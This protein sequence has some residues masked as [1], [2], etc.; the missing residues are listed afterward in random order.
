MGINGMC[1]CMCKAKHGTAVWDSHLHARVQHKTKE[2]RTGQDRIRRNKRRWHTAGSVGAGAWQ[3]ITLW[4]RSVE[5]TKTSMCSPCT[6]TIENVFQ[7]TLSHPHPKAQKRN[8]MAVTKPYSKPIKSGG[9]SY[10]GPK[11][12]CLIQFGLISNGTLKP[13]ENAFFILPVPIFWFKVFW[14]RSMRPAMVVDT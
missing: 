4:H 9:T 1:I 5:E 8:H 12:Y 14:G 13:S 10:C 6:N 11:T 2:D 7:W 3:N